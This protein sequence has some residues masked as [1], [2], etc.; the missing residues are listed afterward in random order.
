MGRKFGVKQSPASVL[1]LLMNE[2]ATFL[3]NSRDA[4]ELGL[5]L[6]RFFF[7]CSKKRMYSNQTT[8]FFMHDLYEIQ[9][10]QG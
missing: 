6:S 4:P 5:T 7:V 8:L 3:Q 2:I 1:H 10:A 9:M